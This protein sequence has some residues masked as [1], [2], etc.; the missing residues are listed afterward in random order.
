MKTRTTI[1]TVLLCTAFLGLPGWAWGPR[2]QLA[3]VL[4]AARMT[5]KEANIP[6][7][8][9][10][11]DLRNGASV[12][13]E[14]VRVQYPDAER[15]PAGAIEAEMYLLQAM[16]SQRIDP[17]FAYRLG[18]LGKLV[19]QATAP[20]AR[21]NPTY[22]N[23]YYADVEE[24]I[25]RTELKTAARRQVEPAAY[26]PRVQRE[27]QTRED[28]IVKDYQTGLG[29]KGVAGA[30]LAED[31]SR[32]V[33]AVAD[34]WHTILTGNVVVANIA[35]SQ[36][37]DY[38]VDSLKFYLSRHHRQ[39][40]DAAYARLAGMPAQT[41][42]LRNRIGDMFFEY[43]EFDRGIKEYEAVVAAEPNRRDV[44]EKISGYYVRVGDEALVRNE[45]EQA[46]DAFARAAEVD[47]LH[48]A[49]QEKLLEAQ[50]MIGD[51]D[52]RLETA[53]QAI[54]QA[55]TLETQ[56]EQ[57]RLRRNYAQALA[58]LR[59]V[60]ILYKSVPDEFAAEN[61]AARAGLNNVATLMR[62]VKGELVRNA[63][64]FSGSSTASDLRRL[65]TG[66]A[67]QL[68]EETLRTLL[69]NQYR[70]EIAK[71]ERDLRQRVQSAGA[72]R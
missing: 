2:A 71:L 65:A 15:D 43:G 21:G 63:E 26:F 36:M 62:D 51:R 45:L 64:T 61:H 10:E 34:V 5:S 53:R 49:A 32:S 16:R 38:V 8:N 31:A 66:S 29:F 67:R 4:T 7:V 40:I 27:A 14:T 28:L 20:L 1:L 37:R 35:D 18:V 3:V 48:A 54:E 68:D 41:P 42:E 58:T 33:N 22:R 25:G 19:A 17:Y 69:A 52:A 13:S 60:E 6:L 44:I 12:S 24:N 59:Q 55:K 56:A 72:A 50:R 47:K 30:A 23:L 9:L 70:S 11:R 57:Q 39:E 46:R